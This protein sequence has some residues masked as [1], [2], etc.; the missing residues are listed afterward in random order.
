MSL[1]QHHSLRWQGLARHVCPA[2]IDTAGEPGSVEPNAHVQ[3]QSHCSQF[4]MMESVL[5]LT[6]ITFLDHLSRGNSILAEVGRN[7]SVAF[8]VIL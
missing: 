5:N 2:Y 6:G 3:R 4:A 8:W 1:E 7:G